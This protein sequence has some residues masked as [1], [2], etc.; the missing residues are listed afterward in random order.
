MRK[1]HVIT[2]YK[3]AAN[4]PKRDLDKYSQFGI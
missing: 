4:W 2:L 3:K 1:T